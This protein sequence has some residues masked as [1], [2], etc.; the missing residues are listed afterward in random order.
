MPHIFLFLLGIRL[1]LYRGNFDNML[2]S[3][4]PAP[5]PRPPARQVRPHTGLHLL[6]RQYGRSTSSPSNR[7]ILSSYRPPVLVLLFRFSYVQFIAVRQK[8]FGSIH[9]YIDQFYPPVG[10]Q[11]CS[12]FS[13][14]AYIPSLVTFGDIEVKC[15]FC[16]NEHG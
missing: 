2:L 11:F 14:I 1:L 9:K 5:A 8:P 4:S 7:L 3:L 6:S 16:V 12:A 15:T 10:D 13:F